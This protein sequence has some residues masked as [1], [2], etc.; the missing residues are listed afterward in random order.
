MPSSGY[1]DTKHEQD[2]KQCVME[3]CG[4]YQSFLRDACSYWECTV[5]EHASNHALP[6]AMS[7]KF[8]VNRRWDDEFFWPD[9]METRSARD[10]MTEMRRAISGNNNYQQ[11]G[12]YRKD[13]ERQKA[14][15]SQG[16]LQAK[17]HGYSGV[18]YE[19]CKAA[20]EESKKSNRVLTIHKRWS[21][22]LCMEAH[23]K[24]ASNKVEYFL[25]GKAKCH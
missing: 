8:I 3:K 19:K 7:D 1:H 4:E 24:D 17:C 16:C 9:E 21:T 11:V 12:R 25:C 6:S 22:R 18:T 13:V 14:T 5:S 20:C 15:D 10:I 2:Y 23:C